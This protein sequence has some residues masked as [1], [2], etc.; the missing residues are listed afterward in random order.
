MGSITMNPTTP[1]SEGEYLLSALE[2]HKQGRLAQAR[3]LY[4]QIL[5]NNPNEITSLHMLG[6]IRL[7]EG[8]GANACRLIGRA[9]SLA[10]QYFEANL[11]M[12]V[13]LRAIDQP[14]DAIEYFDHSISLRPDSIEAH[15]N[16]GVTLQEIGRLDEALES[17]KRVLSQD[18]QHADSASNM[19]LIH[20]QRGDFTRG[21][22]LYETRFATRQY[23]SS[24][25]LD[26][27]AKTW[28]GI[29]PLS[30][31]T[32]LIFC[33]Q[34]LG[35]A[36]Q[37]ARYFRLI[38]QRA[39][40]ANVT[41]LA[42]R[43]LHRIFR[44]IENTFEIV[45][46]IKDRS[47]DFK[48]ALMS[49][50]AIFNTT[51]D[52]IPYSTESYISVNSRAVSEWERHVDSASHHSR[53][54]RIGLMWRGGQATPIKGRSVE[55][56]RLEELLDLPMDF[57][58]CKSKS[59]PTRRASLPHTLTSIISANHSADQSKPTLPIPPAYCLF[60]MSS[61]ASTRAWHTCQPRWAGR[62]GSFFHGLVTGA[63][64]KI[65]PTALGIQMSNS[66][67]NNN[68]GTG[69]TLF[70]TS[71]NRLNCNSKR[72]LRAVCH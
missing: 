35:D 48:I 14:I 12:G 25:S 53:G 64:W 29:D 27:S 70:C 11:N 17:Y 43:S 1:K 4:Q 23:K 20:L 49:A 40:T 54:I 9:L 37:F 51:A 52:N 26:I 45:E 3:A 72:S 69:A 39:P 15:Y 31:K 38:R 50:P 65:A 68:P 5:A 41:V 34:G 2:L 19:A 61:L 62:R 59:L 55:L 44:S 60:W 63:G 36:I 22:R 8:D 10:P 7:A 30:D 6:V 47:F 46:N 13:A 16:R 71:K 21:W 58:A 42:H 57:S 33:E 18:P 32:L 24:H 28:N 67:D 56:K 66:F